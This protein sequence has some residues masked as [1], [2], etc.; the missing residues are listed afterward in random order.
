MRCPRCSALDDKVVDSRA[1]EDG[2]AIRRRRECLTCQMRFTTYERLD[3]VPMVVVK[4]SGQREPF[5]ASKIVAGLRAASKN[6]PVSTAQIEAM[7]A[8]IE[9]AL[10]LEG[11]E[12]A[13]GDIGLAV[14]KRLRELDEVAYVRFASVY[15]G[16]TGLEDFRREVGLLEKHPDSAAGPASP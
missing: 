14:L 8:E 4:R 9:E 13:S 15:K 7:A 6:R 3:E 2:S 1:V 11:P 5:D 10:R 16:F 12:V